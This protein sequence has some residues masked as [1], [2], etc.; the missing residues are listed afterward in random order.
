MYKRIAI[1]GTLVEVILLI[2][3]FVVGS[4]LMNIKAQLKEIRPQLKEE[5]ISLQTVRLDGDIYVCGTVINPK[6]NQSLYCRG[7]TDGY[8]TSVHESQI[9]KQLQQ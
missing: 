5:Y 2:A 4:Q 7:F 8:S 9:D 6:D 3:L 1:I